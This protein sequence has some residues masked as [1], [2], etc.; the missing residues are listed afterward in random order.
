M[1]ARLVVHLQASYGNLTSGLQVARNQTTATVSSIQQSVAGLAGSS[2][3][4]TALSQRAEAV[5]ESMY[6]AR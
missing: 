3:S 5:A 1:L 2:Q 4:L 6:T